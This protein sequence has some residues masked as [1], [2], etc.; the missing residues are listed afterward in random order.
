MVVDDFMSKKLITVGMDD[1]LARVKE[2]F[3]HINFHHLLV[4]QEGRLCGV[5][6]DRD[7]LKHLSPFVGSLHET[8]RDVATL[9]KRAHQIMTPHPLTLPRTA[10]LA[11]AVAIFRNHSLSC[12]PIVNEEQCPVGIITWHDLLQFVR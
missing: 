4:V 10:S 12:I 2:I 11:E 3:D 5:I 9:K 6:S 7:L 1:T 8:A